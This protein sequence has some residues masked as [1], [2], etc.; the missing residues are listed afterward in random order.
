MMR[1]DKANST[2]PDE[3]ARTDLW[4]WLIPMILSGLGILMVTST[5]SSFVYDI[6]GSP[7]TMGLRQFRS[8]GFGFMMMMLTICIPTRFWRNIA[9]F[10]WVM[11][12]IMLICTLIPGIGSSVG[13]ARRWLRIAGIS[14]QPSEVAM[15][16]V[17]LRM[18][19]LFEK[20]SGDIWTCFKAVLLLICI[21]IFPVLMQPDL[22]SAILLVLVCMG[23]FV[24][25]NGWK[26]PLMTGTAGALLLLLLI[27][28]EPYRL[29]RWDAF[30]DPF[31]DPLNTGFQTIQGLIAF[32]NGGTWGAGLGHGF[33]KLHYLPAAYTDFIFAA[34]GEELGL[35]GTLGVLALMTMWLARC[36][37]IYKQTLGGFETS[38]VWGITLTIVGPFFVNVGG[39]T[40]LIPLTGMPLPFVSYG[41]SALVMS[42]VSIGIL[43][44]VQRD[45]AIGVAS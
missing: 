32:A 1:H 16:A 24:E 23:M 42:W 14:I 36:R 5:T 25:R 18:G 17:V 28:R 33:Q 21:T 20:H 44:R 11:S 34:L 19:K 40:K 31:A 7:F 27:K 8:L 4:L 2:S 9:A 39:V 41:G 3:P 22:G 6:S 43:L 29:R 12:L 10:M 35:I 26:L 30:M 45:I 38:I 13:G 15:L 37:F